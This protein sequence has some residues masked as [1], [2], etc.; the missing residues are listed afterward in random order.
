MVKTAL[1]AYKRPVK[2]VVSPRVL[3]EA[4]AQFGCDSLVGAALENEGGVG[5]A[6]AHWEYRLYQG[7]L[8]VATNLFAAY[9][10]PATMSRLTLAFMEDTG[11]YDADWGAAGFLDWGY[12]AGCGFASGT[13]EAYVEVR[14]FL[15]VGR[16]CACFQS[17]CF[18]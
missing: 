1:D 8:M 16:V 2:Y 13:C 17:R 12:R 11:W 7:E 10:K 18:F 4:R 3:A 15:L 6:N 5:S 14:V 9:G